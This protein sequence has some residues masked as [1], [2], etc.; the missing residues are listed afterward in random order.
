MVVPGLKLNEI[1]SY[2][3]RW[4]SFSK[5]AFCVVDRLK[6]GL[7]AVKA[8]SSQVC[9]CDLQQHFLEEVFLCIIFQVR[10]TYFEP[11]EA[12]VSVEGDCSCIWDQRF[13]DL[14]TSAP[15]QVQV[16]FF[17]K[18]LHEVQMSSHVLL[19]SV[20]TV[21]H[22]FR[23]EWLRLI[24]F[25]CLV[26][27]AEWVAQK[28]DNAMLLIQIAKRGLVSLWVYSCSFCVAL[29]DLVKVVD[30][31]QDADSVT[32]DVLNAAVDVRLAVGILILEITL[33]QIL[34]SQL[35]S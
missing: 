23:L 5:F 7:K 13:P 31:W 26:C 6:V 18:E 22:S 35:R 16:S 3:G 20:P 29:A 14:L 15:R 32:F 4:G 21:N 27:I 8:L 9:W 28:L 19:V 2:V 33:C 12:K 11:L 25:C 1:C 30:S 17:E 24:L 10:E 34:A